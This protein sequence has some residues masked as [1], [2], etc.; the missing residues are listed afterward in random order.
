MAWRQRRPHPPHG[1]GFRFPAVKKEEEDLLRIC[2]WIWSKP[3]LIDDDTKVAKRVAW[4]N[5]YGCLTK[6]I[7]WAE[8][9][10]LLDSLKD[11]RPLRCVVAHAMVLLRELE[12]KGNK[13][14]DPTGFIKKAVEQAGG[15][16]VDL[17]GTV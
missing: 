7:D 1:Q 17:A 6:P 9:A 11:G 14:A 12:M 4:L 3:E 2:G 8:V 16:E 10:D 13:V 15:D 5:K